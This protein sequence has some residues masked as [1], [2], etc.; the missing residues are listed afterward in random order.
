[1][2]V[3]IVPPLAE[4]PANIEAEQHVL[5]TILANARR[6]EL[7]ADLLEPHHFADPLLA[8][9][10]ADIRDRVRAGQHVDAVTLRSHYTA[11][12]VLE[13][14]G[15]ARYL[16]ELL[17]SHMPVSTLLPYA[18]VITDAWRRREVIRIT[19]D[20]A[21]RA[22]LQDL[23]DPGDAIAASTAADLLALAD[24]GTK[25]AATTIGAAAEAAL[26]AADDAR[27]NGGRVRGVPTGLAGLD[28]MLGGFLP[29]QLVV[30]GARPAVGKTGTALCIALAA[31]R[32][33][34]GV[35]FFSLEMSAPELAERLLS[36][37]TGIR[38]TAI[39]DGQL[40]QAEWDRLVA[41]R[42]ELAALPIQIDHTPELT[43][44]R[45]RLRARAM[46]RRM[47]LGLVAIDHLGLLAPPSGMDRANLVTITEENSKAL[48]ALA[49]ELGVPV[50]ALAQ[51]NRALEAREDKRPGLADLRWSGSI[52]Q[53]AD[54]AMF[55]HRAE[56]H[57]R[58][59]E[60]S[61]RADETAEKHT[62]R[63]AAWRAD[64][65]EAEG[66]G[67][68]IVAKQRR[69]PTGVVPIQFDG[70]LCRVTDAECSR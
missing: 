62:G 32:A 48:K 47:K 8:R 25:G 31:A 10:F 52:E 43:V 33:G 11:T 66:R 14:V 5:G 26:Q 60:P 6:F 64:V 44:N 54:V 56:V 12:G 57:L 39:R 4:P 29:G 9:I 30:L 45:V 7:V 17:S 42:N 13:E 67:E 63:L 55:L 22:Q 24:A 23:A 3:Y 16:G 41:T 37:M 69:G 53:D 70:A 58:G 36:N 51:L 20:A 34:I 40:S 35:A 15:G 1:M 18:Q 46:S 21:G 65:A 68:L 38:G 61:Q 59:R 28:R 50:L 27:R 19:R 2:A 49:K